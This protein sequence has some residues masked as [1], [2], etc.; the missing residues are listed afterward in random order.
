M[1]LFSL[2]LLSVVLFALNCEA[3]SQIRYVN[4]FPQFGNANVSAIHSI[5]DI[6]TLYT[7]IAPGALPTYKSIDSTTWNFFAS[8]DKKVLAG[9]NQYDL[10]EGDFYTIYSYQKTSKKLSNL[11]IQD[12]SNPPTGNFSAVRTLNLGWYDYSINV[13]ATN[14][15]NYV[16]ITWN[17]VPYA[18]ATDYVLVPPGPYD[19]AW[20][21]IGY[22]KRSIQQTNCTVCNGVTL[23]RNKSYTYIVMPSVYLVTLD[24]TLSTSKRDVRSRRAIQKASALVERLS[25]KEDTTNDNDNEVENVAPELVVEKEVT[26]EQK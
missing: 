17:D 15:T 20:S 16:S 8:F 25:E 5:F 26:N 23:K 24:G 12:K 19:F 21:T 14:A 1:K 10:T 7:E 18:S 22:S 13:T 6:K 4:A 2:V 9:S 11:V 3:T